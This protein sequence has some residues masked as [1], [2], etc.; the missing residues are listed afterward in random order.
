MRL[1]P[2]EPYLLLDVVDIGKV[3]RLLSEAYGDGVFE[4]DER[5]V[6]V[7][8]DR[9]AARAILDHL[10]NGVG[11]FTKAEYEEYRWSALLDLLNDI[12]WLAAYTDV[13]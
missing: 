13:S 12:Q 1:D 3:R 11:T 4:A 5:A 9:T 7:V 10:S 8:M 6:F 2:R